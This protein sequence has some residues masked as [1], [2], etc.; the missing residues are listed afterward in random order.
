MSILHHSVI[1]ENNRNTY[2]AYDVIDFRASFPTRMMNLNSLRITGTLQVRNASNNDI[3]TELVQ[4][5]ERIGAHS[6]FSNIQSFVGGVAID[7]IMEYPRMCKMLTTA[8]T[9][10]ADMFQ[11]KNLCELRAP[12]EAV[13]LQILKGETTPVACNPVIKRKMDFSI[14]PL[15]GLNQV[16]SDRKQLSYTKSGD[17]RV[18]LTLNRDNAVFFGNSVVEGFNYQLADLRL[19]YTSYPDDGDR[20]QAIIFKRRQGLKQSFASNTASLNFNY[21]MVANKIFGSFLK[22]ADEN[23]PNLNTQALQKVP[24]VST[25][26]FYWNNATNEYISYEMRSDVEILERYI[27]AVGET[28]RNSASLMNVANNDGWG[29]GLN[30]GSFVDLMATKLSVVIESELSSSNPMLLTLFA[31]GV[32]QL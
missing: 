4:L 32:S 5:D 7:N 15:I 18:V 14:K 19:E 25:L 17:V 13:A 16:Y 12:N 27:D 24:N 6:L 20:E 2:S 23:M 9:N 8:N 10:S 29:I 11:A 1:P 3:T 26:G 22:Q 28:G 21:P 31:E 30:L